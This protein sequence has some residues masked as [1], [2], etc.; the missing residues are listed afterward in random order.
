MNITTEIRKLYKPI[1][2]ITLGNA[3]GVSYNE[4]LPDVRL[5]SFIYYYWEFKTTQP[6]S[7]GFDYKVVPNGCIDIFFEIGN[8]QK[9]F[10]TGLSNKHSEILL[11]TS[12]HYV[13]ICFVPAMF[14]HLYHI[15]ASELSNRIEDFSDVVPK[16]SSFIA[17]N[18]TPLFTATAIKKLFDIYFLQHIRHSDLRLDNRLREAVYIIFKNSGNLNLQGN[19]DVGI[20][21]R[22]LRRLFEFYIGDTPKTFSRIVR[23]QKIIQRHWADHGTSNIAPYFDEGYYDQSHFIR[24]FKSFY[25]AT[26][27]KVR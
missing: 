3:E 6:L 14:S 26:P 18:F 15:K 20:S 16:T 27:S 5:Q 1:Q 17:Q 2:P 19:L 25:G 4:F 21:S 13:G 22:Q 24:E 23:F 8:P 11:E 10:V 12:F 9:N 7:Q